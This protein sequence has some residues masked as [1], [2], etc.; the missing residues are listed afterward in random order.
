M[1]FAELRV[2]KIIKIFKLHGNS[3]I[4]YK[5]IVCQVFGGPTWI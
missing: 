1:I 5:R 2:I 3:V 4:F